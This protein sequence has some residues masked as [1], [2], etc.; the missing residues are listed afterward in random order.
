MSSISTA[1]VRERE[2][3]LDWITQERFQSINQVVGV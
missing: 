3:A 1:A 2:R